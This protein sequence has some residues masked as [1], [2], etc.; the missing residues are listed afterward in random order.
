MDGVQLPQDFRATKRSSLLLATH[1]FYSQ[2]PNI[3]SRPLTKKRIFYVI[4][5][6]SLQFSYYILLTNQIPL[7]NS[8]QVLRYWILM[9]IVII[10]LPVMKVVFFLTDMW[11]SHG[12]LWAILEGD[13]LANP[14][15]ITAF[16][17]DSIRILVILGI[18]KSTCW[19][20]GWLWW[21]HYFLDS[22]LSRGYLAKHRL[23]I[24][25]KPFLIIIFYIPPKEETKF[26][27]YLH[28]CEQMLPYISAA[29]HWNYAVDVV[30]YMQKMGRL[31]NS[32]LEPF[33][34]G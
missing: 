31:P 34:K 25:V 27:L 14:M 29:T 11:L 10:C 1:P 12:Q 22:L 15:L 26:A 13:S 8:F 20:N 18:A 33:M 3:L 24:L 5:L 32:L 28:V 7:L 21:P 6:L 17:T 2:Q 16:S 30:V 4:L 9:S 23:K 19:W